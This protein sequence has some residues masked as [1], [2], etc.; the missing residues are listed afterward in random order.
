MGECMSIDPSSHTKNTKILVQ[1]KPK[2]VGR[3]LGRSM[4][5]EIK[6]LRINEY[7]YRYGFGSWNKRYVKKWLKEEFEVVKEKDMHEFRKDVL[8][9]LDR[10]ENLKNSMSI[11]G[12]AFSMYQ[13]KGGSAEVVIEIH[14]GPTCRTI[15]TEKTIFEFISVLQKE[16]K[17]ELNNLKAEINAAFGKEC[18]S[19]NDA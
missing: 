14:D 6:Y 19:D 5:Y 16:Y 7:E 4:F 9:T 3:Y 15:V 1:E 2:I 13:E 12:D 11:L 18:M 8:N 17:N 10:M